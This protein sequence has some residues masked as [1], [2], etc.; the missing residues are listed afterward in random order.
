MFFSY[1]SFIVASLFFSLG[2]IGEFLI[3]LF[4]LHPLQKEEPNY[5]F[6]I[7]RNRSISTFFDI[8]RHINHHVIYKKNDY[9][10]ARDYERG[11]FCWKLT[12]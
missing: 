2:N 9:K 6:N 4:L 12:E 8:S 3:S 11:A 5:R 7:N 10:S 1:V